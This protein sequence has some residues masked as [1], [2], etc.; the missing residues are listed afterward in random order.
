MTIKEVEE[1]TGLSRSNVRFYEKEKLIAP[2]R[3]EN[4]GYR[5]YS[6]SDIENLKKIAYLRT[7]GISIEDIRNIISKKV[8]L[9]K[10]IQ[11]QNKMLE[12]QMLDMSRAKMLC[13]R[14]L[15]EGNIAYDDLKVER[16][17][18]ELEDYWMAHQP[19]LKVDSVSFLYLWGCFITWLIITVLC[20]LAAVVFFEKLPPE[21]PV[22]WSDGKASSLVDKRFIFAYPIACMVIRYVVRPFIYG[23][24]QMN[25]PYRE[26]IAEYVTNYL[27]FIA[28]SVE[29]FS[30]L[31]VYGVVENVIAVLFVDTLVLIGLLLRGLAKKHSGGIAEC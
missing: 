13:E 19:V 5:D 26:A 23:K 17:V 8:P 9:R 10:V 1:Q 12:S 15:D 30:I 2:A 14:M 28:L 3:N 20:F 7:L 6:D 4:N 27:C 31:F 25:N 11:K 24:L 18:T 22:Q 29:I 16:Y 21:I